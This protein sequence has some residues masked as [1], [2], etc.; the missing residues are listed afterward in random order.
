M[1]KSLL[2][3][4]L[5][6]IITS[7]WR[8]HSHS[9]M[10]DATMFGHSPALIAEEMTLPLPCDRELWE[11]SQDPP[12]PRFS[13]DCLVLIEPTVQQRRDDSTMYHY[14]LRS[15]NVFVQGRSFTRKDQLSDAVN[16]TEAAE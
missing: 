3:A 4:M 10:L 8:G 16:G 11:E 2:A 1:M 6:L 9:N 13:Q 5:P 14:D 7:D 15:P 12:S